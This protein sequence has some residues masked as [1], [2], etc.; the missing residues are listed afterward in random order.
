MGQQDCTYSIYLTQMMCERSEE[1]ERTREREDGKRHCQ[2]HSC[3]PLLFSWPFRKERTE[4]TLPPRYSEKAFLPAHI[5]GLR[6]FLHAEKKNIMSVQH[7]PIGG[8]KN[9]RMSNR[10]S[11]SNSG[12]DSSCGDASSVKMPGFEA[13][14]RKY[15]K[16]NKKQKNP[17]EPWTIN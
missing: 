16:K 4:N 6:H 10:M 2:M 14:E 5:S 8:K 7:K 11:H 17:T 13:D 15:I 1:E 3:F 12:L 9:L